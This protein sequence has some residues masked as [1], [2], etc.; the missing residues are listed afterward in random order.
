MNFLMLRFFNCANL[1]I[2][3]LLKKTRTFL[4]TPRTRADL[5]KGFPE[6]IEG[7][8]YFLDNYL[9]PKVSNDA[10]LSEHIAAAMNDIQMQSSPL[11]S[12]S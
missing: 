3:R 6:D 10:P 12:K 9:H 7:I 1:Y 5:P 11:R 2:Y 4:Y 8:P